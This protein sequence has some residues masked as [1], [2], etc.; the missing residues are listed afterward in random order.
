MTI[1]NQAGQIAQ[2][3]D[4]Y[5]ELRLYKL[6]P[7][8]T[9]QQLS[10]LIQA[11]QYGKIW[12]GA[13]SAFNDPYDCQPAFK[14]DYP[15][16]ICKQEVERRWTEK[17]EQPLSELELERRAIHLM[18][19]A[20]N[21]PAMQDKE[22]AVLRAMNTKFG[23]ACFTDQY[24]SVL[25][26][27]HYATKHQGACIEVPHDRGVLENTEAGKSP[28]MERVKYDPNRPTL[29][30][31]EM[32][33][34]DSLGI[35]RTI[36]NCLITKAQEWEYEREWRIFADGP[37]KYLNIRKDS[38][39]AVTLGALM[40]ENVKKAVIHAARSAPHPVA[41]YQAKL[42]DTKYEIE[43]YPVLP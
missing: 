42:S 41:V 4:H 25:M 39:K 12:A 26:W 22:K 9:T 5:G 15:L 8:E 36:R 32:D 43:R 23:V 18:H 3:A 21:D 33:F 30:L 28:L 7:L 19:A 14:R 17:S 2:N 20:L 24:S 35:M 38:V 34:Q 16:E 11:I 6:Y 31:F 29:A 10:Y 13:P 37:N 27:S 40:D 1:S